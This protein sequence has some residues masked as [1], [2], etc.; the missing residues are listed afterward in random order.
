MFTLSY[1]I[2]LCCTDKPT[3]RRKNKRNFS[4]EV[5]LRKSVIIK[6][7]DWKTL[8]APRHEIEEPY[9]SHKRDN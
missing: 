2:N 9:R 1:V 5:A 3:A 4:D 6:F 7:L 8:N